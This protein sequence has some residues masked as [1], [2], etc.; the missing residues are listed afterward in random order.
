MERHKLIA[1][2]AALL[3]ALL[4]TA[5][6]FA[7]GTGAAGCGADC[8]ACHSL[9]RDEA[10]AV[11]KG[12]DA[13]TSV[14]SVAPSPVRGLYQ[15]V[16]KRGEETGIVYLDFSKKFIIA[17]RII[18]TG[19]RQDMTGRDLDQARHIDPEKLP[20]DNALVLGNPTGGRKL[21]VFTDPECPFCAK[22]HGELVALIKEDPEL[23]VYILLV[24]LDIHPAATAATDAIICASRKNMGAGVRLLEKSFS[25]TTVTKES[26]GRN[27]A[28]EGKKIGRDFGIGVTPTMVFSNGRVVAGTRPRDEIRKI[29]DEAEK[30]GPAGDPANGRPAAPQG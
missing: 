17:G 22:L 2:F 10:A 7:F 27:Y 14:E 28:E 21:Y 11:L 29:L 23:K 18:D 20:L 25:G 30:K 26:C 9:S 19:S 6:S 24:P 13:G 12:L 5:P 4:S 1:G 16:V 3:L 15:L 8:A